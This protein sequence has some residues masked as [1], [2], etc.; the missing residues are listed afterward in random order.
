[1]TIEVQ[2]N[3]GGPVVVLPSAMDLNIADDLLAAV[4]KAETAHDAYWIDGS[5]VTRTVTPCLQVL[6]AALRGHGR[7]SKPSDALMDSIVSLGFLPAVSDK[8][9][10]A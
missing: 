2:V 10:V 6:V 8:V 5:E 4:V 1:M 3:D 7:L 9:D